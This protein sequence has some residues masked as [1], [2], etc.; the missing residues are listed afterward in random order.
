[1]F[2]NNLIAEQPAFGA[3]QVLIS[4]V[5]TA[6]VEK[7]SSLW[8]SKTAETVG[9]QTVAGGIQHATK[10][11]A[12]HPGSAMASGNRRLLNVFDN[13]GVSPMRSDNLRTSSKLHTDFLRLPLG[14]Q[15]QSFTPFSVQIAHTFYKTVSHTVLRSVSRPK[16]V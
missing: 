4:K 1:M 11:K 9:A 5:V 14:G 2:F 10:R 13:R 3:V 6:G 8:V 16:P 15:I 12:A 7:A